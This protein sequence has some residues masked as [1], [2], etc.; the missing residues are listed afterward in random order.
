MT[1]T[2]LPLPRRG[3]QP[4][5]GDAVIC[6]R[7]DA[8]GH[9]ERIITNKVDRPALAAVRAGGILRL[10]SFADFRMQPQRKTKATA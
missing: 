7:D 4:Q 6:H 8:K 10:L 3:R 1:A 9:I 2:V 5:V